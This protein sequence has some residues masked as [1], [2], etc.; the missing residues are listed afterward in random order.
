MLDQQRLADQF[1]H[2]AAFPGWPSGAGQRGGER[3][4][5][6]E[7]RVDPP[8]VAGQSHAFGQ[9]VGDHQKARPGEVLDRE[10]AVGERLL[11]PFRR[12]EHQ[13]LVV[14]TRQRPGDASA[15]LAQHFVFLQWRQ[16]EQD[17]DAKL[18]QHDEAGLSGGEGQRRGRNEIGSL[19]AAGVD[20]L[21]EQQRPRGHP[22]RQG[23]RDRGFFFHD[24][25]RAY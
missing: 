23:C 20:P 2:G 22:W 19:Q 15:E 11:L 6:V 24:S 14:V 5:R 7:H 3:L 4:D 12:L 25:F 9:R 8:F 17:G 1:E 21:A 10:M 13:R 16:A 18:V